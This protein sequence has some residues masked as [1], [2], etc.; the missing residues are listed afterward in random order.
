MKVSNALL[1]TYVWMLIK[2]EMDESGDLDSMLPKAKNLDDRSVLPHFK[3]HCQYSGLFT[4]FVFSRLKSLTNQA[5]V[6]L[7]MKGTRDVCGHVYLVL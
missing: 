7:F 1:V 3:L 6:M 2:Q 4:P 5:S